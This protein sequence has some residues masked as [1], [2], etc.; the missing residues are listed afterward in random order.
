MGAAE[1]RT[2]LPGIDPRES[3]IDRSAVTDA[4]L[5]RGHRGA[6]GGS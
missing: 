2:D 6:G 4:D 3:D 1:G 5:G